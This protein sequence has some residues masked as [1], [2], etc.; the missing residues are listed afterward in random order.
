MDQTKS[1]PVALFLASACS[2]PKSPDGKHKCTELFHGFQGGDGDREQVTVRCENDC[3][4]SASYT[5][6]RDL[7]LY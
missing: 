7:I 4:S 6:H 1:T 5:K 3:G 2:S